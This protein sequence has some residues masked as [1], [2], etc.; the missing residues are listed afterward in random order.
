M[1]NKLNIK[2]YFDMAA[3]NWDKLCHH[4]INKLK[5]IAY[6]ADIKPND[7][8]I[9]IACGTGVLTEYILEYNPS[10]LLGIDISDRMIDIAKSKYTDSRVEFLASDIFDVKYDNFDLAIIYSAYPHFLDKE[11]LVTKLYNIL[12]TNGRFLIAHSESKE[13]INSIHSKAF[14]VENIST[15]LSPIEKEKVPFIESFDID[16]MIDTNDLYILSGTKKTEKH[17]TEGD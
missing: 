14:D 6:I 15:K 4:D 16:I 2:Y 9:D 1:T 11:Q 12:T 10:K 17:E 7:S 3:A 5:L 8:V 13:A